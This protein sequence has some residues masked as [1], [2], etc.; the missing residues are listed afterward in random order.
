LPLNLREGFLSEF[1]LDT[2]Y[3][4][5]TRSLEISTKLRDERQG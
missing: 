2:K 5:A 3:L 4:S 1:T